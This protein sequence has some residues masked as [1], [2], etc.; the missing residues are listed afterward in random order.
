[1][2]LVGDPGDVAEHVDPSVGGDTGLGGSAALWVRADVGDP[3]GQ[4]LTRGGDLRFGLC[5]FG[6]VDVEVERAG[7]LGGEAPG[8]R[9]PD[10][11]CDSGERRDLV[12]VSICGA[13]RIARSAAQTKCRLASRRFLPPK[14]RSRGPLSH[15]WT[16]VRLREHRYRTELESAQ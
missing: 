16:T 2:A 5:Q 3:S 1:M 9:P 14:C 13:D 12:R 8:R 10:S 4:L 6:F 7:R 11:R 15:T